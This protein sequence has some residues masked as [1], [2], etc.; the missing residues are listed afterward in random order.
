M[1]L[2]MAALAHDHDIEGRPVLPIAD[3]M[4]LEPLPGPA[5]FAAVHGPNERLT[6]DGGTE[7]TATH[8]H[9]IT[10]SARR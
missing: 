5:A 9:S 8:G 10:V 2:G 1:F 3:V 6:P 7:F 4:E